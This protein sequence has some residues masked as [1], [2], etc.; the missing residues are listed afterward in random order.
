MTSLEGKE[1]LDE[2]EKG[3]LD[4]IDQTLK[5]IMILAESLL[6]PQRSQDCFAAI[7]DNDKRTRHYWQ[8]ILHISRADSHFSLK[9]Y[10]LLHN[11]E[12]LDLTRKSVKEQIMESSMR[13][14]ELRENGVANRGKMLNKIA[15]HKSMRHGKDPDKVVGVKAL[16]NAERTKC[17]HNEL[18]KYKHTKTQGGKNLEVPAQSRNIDNMWQVLKE[19]RKEIEDVD[20]ETVN[21]E[22]ET[23]EYL[24][25]WCIRHLGRATSTPLYNGA[26]KNQLDPR[27]A[28]N[29]MEEI[30]EGEIKLPR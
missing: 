8:M 4:L 25:I 21:G 27:T 1:Y 19:E 20:W 3:K 15:K 23:T 6:Q 10:N 28:G 11:K 12:N 9:K 22:E 2:I 29:I 13:I 5:K 14:R 17:N 24:L 16:L 7:M 30:I 26:W 18:I